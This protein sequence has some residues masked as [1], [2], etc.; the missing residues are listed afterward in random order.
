MK[1]FVHLAVV[2]AAAIQ[3]FGELNTPLREWRVI[4]DLLHRAI[5]MVGLWH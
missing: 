2:I 1:F 3:N 4:A 5:I